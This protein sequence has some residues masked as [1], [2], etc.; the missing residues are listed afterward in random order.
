MAIT[1]NEFGV[2]ADGIPVQL[3][4]LTNR[5][6]IT[7]RITTY[8]GTLVSLDAPG[9]D[10]TPADVVLG[11]DTLD[12]YLAMHPYFG[13]LIGR[14]GNRIAGGAFELDGKRYSLARNDGPNHLHG[15]LRG[16]SRAVWQA[17]AGESGGEPV[18]ELQYQSRDGEEGYPGNLLAT[19]R[20]TLT[21]NDE[22]RLAYRATTDHATVVNLT[23]HSYFNLAGAGDILAHELWL[24][25]EHYLPTNETLIPTGEL[26]P[27]RG[28]PFDFTSA[29]AVGARIAADDQQLRIGGG[30]DHTFV[31]RAAGG[32]PHIARLTDPASGRRLDVYTTQPGVQFYSGNM[33]VG[34][35][36]GKGGQLYSRHSALCLETQHFPDSPNHPAFPTAILR[37][38]EVYDHTTIFQFGVAD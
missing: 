11:F 17:T 15:G 1:Q 4:T 14:Y 22:L 12:G 2:T 7:A 30:Y 38:G 35:I 21:D 29:T 18:L 16:F 27:V 5:N 25:A 33:I 13:A 24:A 31:H 20:Y 10:G 37:P 9:R 34:A 6:R 19:V 32:C 36:R 3:F 23:N 28:T 26:R 8:G